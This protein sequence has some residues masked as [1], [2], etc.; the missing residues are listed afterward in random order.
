MAASAA[1][2]SGRGRGRPRILTDEERAASAKAN[3]RKW[4]ERNKEHCR[5]KN[6]EWRA[7]NPEKSR[8]ASLKYR[9]RQLA[10]NRD[11]FRERERASSARSYHKRMAD[12]EFA[13]KRREYELT[14]YHRRMKDPEYRDR[15]RRAA[16]ARNALR[17]AQD[18]DRWNATN[19]KKVAAYKARH[20]GDPEYI[21]RR[22][23]TARAAYERRKNDPEYR[24]YM[25]RAARKHKAR[26]RLRRAAAHAD[27]LIA[28]IGGGAP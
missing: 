22:R 17:K 21:A 28:A 27:A 25:R 9:A 15:H 26:Q 14:A 2:K 8:Q 10:E 11:E 18:P 4:R 1:N 12:P 5:Q 6:R 20:R 19:R 7:A 16:N 3:G 13:K 23:Q 24:E